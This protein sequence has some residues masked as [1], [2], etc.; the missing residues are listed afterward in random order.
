MTA[1]GATMK[2]VGT[3]GRE[4]TGAV[5]TGDCLELYDKNKKKLSSY[6]I[7][8]YGD[9]N[10]DGEINELDLVQLNQHIM[11]QQQLSGCYL[12]AANVNRQDD[13]VNVLDLVHMNQSL[14]G[15][16]TIQQ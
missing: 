3:D 8:I 2:L 16:K 11:G 4:N 5:A 12:L 1:Q 6:T 10:G 15:Q 7:V 9:V 14:Q 13:G